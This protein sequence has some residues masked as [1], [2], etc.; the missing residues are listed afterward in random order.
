MQLVANNRLQIK[1]IRSEMVS[2]IL[3]LAILL[4]STLSWGYLMAYVIVLLFCSRIKF[5]IKKRLI[6]G[7][8]SY[9]IIP[10]IL[11]LLHSL[12]TVI[13]NNQSFYLMRSLNNFIY[14]IASIL[15]S[16]CLYYLH[17]HRSINVLL[18]SIVIYYLTKVIA[19]VVSIGPLIFIKN[20]F[21][22]GSEVLT[23]WLEAHDIGLSLG[24]IILY[25][26]FYE[27]KYVHGKKLALFI[28]CLIFYLCWKRIAL[29]ALL[30]AAVFVII[31][32]KYI[33]KKNR[34]MLIW[35]LIG[36]SICF[37]YVYMIKN[38]E[39][40][41]W[42]YSHDINL[43]GRDNLYRYFSDYY[44]IS[45]TFLGRGSGFIAKLL[46][47]MVR[48]GNGIGS[49]VALHSDI[50]RV[51]IEY[52]FI[53]GL[54]WYSYYLIILPKI[55]RRKNNR[56]GE[57]LFVVAIYSFVIYLTDN[58]SSYILFQAFYMIIPLSEYSEFESKNRI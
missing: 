47:N 40:V 25:L 43:M 1:F 50:L 31:C 44:S 19:A 45:P 18:S 14:I 24:L 37:G 26:L 15:L 35:G 54:L 29:A 21:I 6:N 22:P 11:I 28:S 46:T 48:T 4:P 12:L 13:V 20:I 32:N 52:G 41:T 34:L 8:F 36:V 2:I 9:F 3:I 57:L 58:T 55:F 53:G 10:N 7:Y 16:Y 5:T 33:D 23:K 38:G 27:S 51:Y 42:L 39:L 17:G 56:V 30:I 49:I